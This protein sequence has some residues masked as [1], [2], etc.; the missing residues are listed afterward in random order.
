ML[1]IVH[2]SVSKILHID[3]KTKL[4][5]TECYV[6][7]DDND[8]DNDDDDDDD[9]DDLG[10]TLLSTLTKTKNTD[11][12]NKLRKQEVITVLTHC[13]IT[14]NLPKMTTLFYGNENK[15]DNLVT[16]TVDLLPQLDSCIKVLVQNAIP[17]DQF[18]I[19]IW[20]SKH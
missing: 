3:D 17:N 7:N 19:K 8:D 11:I 16:T 18:K 10:Q 20:I 6:N 15:D 13:M 4:Y 2:Y 9:S 5:N 12:R 14:Q 1:D